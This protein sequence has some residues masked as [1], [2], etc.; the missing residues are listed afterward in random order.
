MVF[1]S[2]LRGGGVG[3]GHRLS[4]GPVLFHVVV[5]RGRQVC[6]VQGFFSLL[7]S[8][9]WPVG[10]F[11]SPGLARDSPMV[12]LFGG[13]PVVLPS[14][15]FSFSPFFFCFA[16]IVPFSASFGAGG[17]ALSGYIYVFFFPLLVPWSRV[18]ASLQ[19]LQVL[20]VVVS[21]SS[22]LS[23]L[24]WL[25]LSVVCHLLLFRSFSF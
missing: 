20:L 14:S 19:S 24:G 8:S 3:S 21:T 22:P 12:V 1:L 18:L 23:L 17:C 2:L 4:G 6:K 16:T 13:V 25:P 10:S 15:S 9:S 11:L 5:V 7:F